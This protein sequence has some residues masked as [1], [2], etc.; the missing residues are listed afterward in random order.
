M[1]QSLNDRLDHLAWYSDKIKNGMSARLDQNYAVT[2]LYTG[3]KMIV[4]VRDRSLTPHLLLD[5]YWELEISQLFERLVHP[6]NVVLDLGANFGYFSL[7]AGA[8]IGD[9]GRIFAIEANPE[10]IPVLTQNCMLNG[11]QGRMTVANFVVSDDRPP[12]RLKL[13]KDYMGN[14][15]ME[16]IEVDSHNEFSAYVSVANTTVDS[17]CEQQQIDRVNI[18]KMDIEGA[19]FRAIRG[20][21][22]C[23]ARNKDHIKILMEYAPQ[24]YGVENEAFIKYLTNFFSH[25]YEVHSNGSYGRLE[26]WNIDNWCMLLLANEEITV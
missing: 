11:L 21:Q 9:N 24:R 22:S 23:L 20:M 2:R 13:F 6:G 18:V 12:M 5:G 15:A 14:S 7:V 4:D 17:Y 10:L 19:E 16:D 25:I 26:S 3:Q 8:K 1:S